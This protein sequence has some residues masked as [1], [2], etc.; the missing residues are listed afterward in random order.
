MDFVLI[1]TQQ[2]YLSN[3]ASTMIKQLL[4]LLLPCYVQEA[5]HVYLNPNKFPQYTLLSLLH[6]SQLKPN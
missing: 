6:F 3:Q 5:K 4:H 1:P 2:L